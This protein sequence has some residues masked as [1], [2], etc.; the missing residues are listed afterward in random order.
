MR[1]P[2]IA[3]DYWEL[4]SA[5]KAHAQYGDRFW[6]PALI[7]RQAIRRGQAA[8]LIFDIEVDNAGKLEIQGERMYVIVS[9]KIGDIYIGILDNQ[10]ACSNFEDNVYLCM[11]AEVPFLAEH[12]IDIDDPPQDYV[13]WQLGQKPERVWPRQ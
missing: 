3:T 1:Q 10:P 13:D 5:E 12:V 11:G 2:S 4:R 9:E 6:I 8:R 7:E